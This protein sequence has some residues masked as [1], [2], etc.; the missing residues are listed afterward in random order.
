M[1]ACFAGPLF[2]MLIGLGCGFLLVL[3]DGGAT[4]VALQPLV[5]VGCA[6]IIALCLALCGASL[7]GG[8]RLSERVGWAMMAWYCLYLIMVLLTVSLSP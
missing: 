1:T 8:L 6:F 5:A 7:A 4:A 3:R 2:N